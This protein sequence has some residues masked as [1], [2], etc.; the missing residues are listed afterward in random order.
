MP[1]DTLKRPDVEAA[2]Q[3][4]HDC[5]TMTLHGPL[6]LA[7]SMRLAEHVLALVPEVT[8]LRFNEDGDG[9]GT[10]AEE[11]ARQTEATVIACSEWP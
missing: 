5:V 11:A 6:P 2:R 9:P 10:M 1:S 3:L 7:T 4:A 8:R